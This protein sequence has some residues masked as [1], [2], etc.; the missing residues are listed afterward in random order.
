[1]LA[2]PNSEVVNR[3]VASYT[4]FPNLRIEVPFSI[5]VGEDLGRTRELLLGV[6][7]GDEDYMDTPGP[8]VVVSELN[9][10][11]VVVVLRAWI[12]D[13]RKHIAKRFQLRERGFE[14]LR[15]ASVDMPFET[16]RSLT[17]QVAV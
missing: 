13:E 10:Y 2:I 9:D 4:N 7:E 12:Y 1:M 17:T 11:N 15:T 5:G 3:T 8:Q 6:L 16:I 14:A